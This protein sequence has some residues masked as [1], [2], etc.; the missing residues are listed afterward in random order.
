MYFEKINRA[1]KTLGLG[2][3]ATLEEIKKVYR[4]LVKKNHPDRHSG[5][6]RAF[7]ERKMSQINQAY[8]YIMDYVRQFEIS[9]EKDAVEQY[10]PERAM[11]RFKDD[12]IS[13]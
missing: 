11:R 13:R 4:D 2:E 8:K 5:K 3:K 7:Y 9:F 1:R 12:W 10:D 6:E